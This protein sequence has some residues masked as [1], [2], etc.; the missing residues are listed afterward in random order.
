LLP[1]KIRISDIIDAV[2]TLT[3]DIALDMRQAC[4]EQA[5]RF[6]V[7]TFAEQLKSYV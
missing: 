2:S 3:P 1:K 6:S 7:E 4:E 5:Q